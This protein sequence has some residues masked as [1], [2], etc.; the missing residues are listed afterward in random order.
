MN[1]FLTLVISILSFCSLCAQSPVAGLYSALTIA[2]SLKKDANAV[3]RLDEGVLEITSPSQYKWRIHQVITI[4][5]EAGAHHL[6]H[7]Y[8]F[9]KFNKIDDLEVKVFNH[10]GSEVKRYRK[11]D[12]QVQSAY[13]GI[14][15]V[16][17]DKIMH[18]NTMPP[19]YPCTVEINVVMESSGYT[20]LPDWHLNTSEESTELFRYVVKVPSLLDIRHRTKNLDLKPLVQ[21]IGSD[22]VYTWEVRNVPSN[23]IDIDGYTAG[24]YMPG[25]EVAP[26]VFEYD[27][28]KGE[29]RDWKSFGG[30]VHGLFEDGSPFSEKRKEEI[31]SLV[32]SSQSDQ[33]KIALL[34]SHLK[35]N[36]RYVSIQLGIG[37]FKPF[38]VQFV[39]DKK[40]GDCK[41][42]T[43]YMRYMLHTVGIKSYPALINT[44]YNAAPADP[45]FPADRFN[46]VILC[47]PLQKDSVW[48]ECTSNSNAAGF[49]G[50][51]TENK[52]ALLLT[53]K[54]GVLVRTPGSNHRNNHLYTRT[55]I[56]LEEDGSAIADSRIY[57]TGDERD[58]FNYLRQVDAD[59]K[60][61]LLVKHMNY[62]LP[63]AFELKFHGDTL[64][65]SAFK[66]RAAYGKFYD[67]TAGSKMFFQQGIHRLS[68]EDLRDT[69]RS[70]EYLFD[71]PYEKV[72]TTV[73]HLPKEIA[74]ESLLPTKELTD[75]NA[76]YKVVMQYDAAQHRVEIISQL[77]LKKH[78]ISAEAY[79]KVVG[80]FREVRRNE[81]QKVVFK[82]L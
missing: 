18:L 72:D 10:V 58:I 38:P 64:N 74:V 67:F 12:F 51:F 61:E 55:D 20:E 52:N 66:L 4:L 8:S 75:E 32:Q 76:S 65:G 57:C 54:G 80:F 46:H 81:E 13:D 28:H 43:N 6:K 42:L 27:G 2:D 3:Y 56:F 50:S 30:F 17:D 40:Y 22:K 23:K 34:Y 14:S 79:Q 11:K 70:I 77:I 35:K 69:K 25:V 45:S 16:T 59:R 9:D 48:L 29:F 31:R 37:G 62:R 60:K 21:A 78:I 49:L 36:M 71:H 39:D 68:D 73:Y 24:N 5:N 44:G 15:L 1:R 53:E 41:A 33:E 63:D 7:V 26:N 19:G 82:R 47:I